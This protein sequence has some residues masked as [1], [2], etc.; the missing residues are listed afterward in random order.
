MD[1]LPALPQEKNNYVFAN[2]NSFVVAQRMAAPLA[3]SN[4]VPADYRGNI[5]NC[6]I[7]LEISQRLRASPLLIMQNLHV[8]EGRPSW[9]AQFLIATINAC[10]R[11]SPLRFSIQDKGTKEVDCVLEYK[12][13]TGSD[14]RKK[15]TPIMG[16]IK[17]HNKSC[18]AWAIERETGERLESSEIS[19][20]MAVKEG[21]Y[22]KNGSK[23]QSMPEQMLRYRAASFFARIYSPELTM[24]MQTA[25]EVYD[26]GIRDVTP[27]ESS[28]EVEF[29]NEILEKST[30]RDEI[31]DIETGEI[32]IDLEKDSP[33]KETLESAEMPQIL[34]GISP[35]D[36]T[37]ADW[38][39][40]ST[41]FINTAYTAPNYE[42]F[43]KFKKKHESVLNNFKKQDETSYNNLILHL[44]ER[45][46]ALVL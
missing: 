1:K 9:S 44:A 45:E 30:K 24:G 37:R 17:V 11:Y 10:G 27:S 41:D 8:I 26:M 31:I 25:D 4:L 20:E 46:K 28:K 32:I 16:K 19:I 22:Q 34:V 29:L 6:L 2:E 21:W 42:S 43:A 18:I 40:F 3:A 15:K 5:G 36:E 35:E 13:E 14:N 12:W 33:S 23:W 38:N 7:A 39:K